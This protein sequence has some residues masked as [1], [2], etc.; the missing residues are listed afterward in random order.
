MGFLCIMKSMLNRLL[1]TTTLLLWLPAAAPGVPQHATPLRI[2]P[3]DSLASN[4]VRIGYIPGS[5]E[6]PIISAASGW[7]GMTA[8]IRVLDHEGA[9]FQ[10]VLS[11]TTGRWAYCGWTRWPEWDGTLLVL[12]P[13]PYCLPGGVSPAVETGETVS[14]TLSGFE[15]LN[16][17]KAAVAMPGMEVLDLLP[18]TMGLFS[19]TTDRD[20][21]YWV[22]VIQEGP[23]GPSVSLLFPVIA[24]G[25]A[26]DVLDGT[27]PAPSPD[28]SGADQVFA[29]MNTWRVGSGLSALERSP[30]LDSIA[31]LRAVE[32]AI[33]GT[34]DHLASGR[35]LQEMLPEGTG[36]FGE[37][38]ARGSGFMEALSM[39]LISPFHLRTCLSDSYA[40]AGIGAA[41]DWRQGQWQ[42][43][44]VQVF[45]GDGQSL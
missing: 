39:V 41:V 33:S 21:L 11:D 30:V 18:D 6:L 9:E 17:P 43:V 8:D 20:G 19:F 14:F 22:E 36:A 32:L 38:I 2:P 7:F 24:G 5:G 35:G 16:S 1:L 15:L 10:D 13:P 42:L 37:N 27:L 26:M 23:N 45:T 28:V 31:G 34:Y 25:D 3:L 29:E 40:F 44:M 4:I 12:A